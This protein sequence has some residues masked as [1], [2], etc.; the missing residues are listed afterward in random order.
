MGSDGLENVQWWVALGTVAATP[1]AFS[2][3][4][5]DVFGIV[6]ATVV[7]VGAAIILVCAT[8]RA[9]TGTR[10]LP[11]PSIGPIVGF[12]VTVS[13]IATLTSRAPAVSA[14]GN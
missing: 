12:Y 11:V 14:L 7:W 1:L 3:S 8:V 13:C 9:M 4:T 10:P 6:E 5:L 2:T